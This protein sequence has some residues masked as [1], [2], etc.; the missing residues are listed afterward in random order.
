[1]EQKLKALSLYH[2]YNLIVL[3]FEGILNPPYEENSIHI[4]L[5]LYEEKRL[6]IIKVTL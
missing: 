3:H 6:I 5:R 1:L 4:S 2:S